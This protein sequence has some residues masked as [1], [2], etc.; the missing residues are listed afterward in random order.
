MN[1][2]WAYSVKTCGNAK[3]RCNLNGSPFEIKRMNLI[4]NKTY[5][6]C[7]DQVGQKTF[8]SLTSNLG[9]VAVGIDVVNGYAHAEAPAI[10]TFLVID[11]QYAEWYSQVNGKRS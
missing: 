8:W 9:Y 2:Q 6:A 3:A 5:A 10:D 11:D 7:V 1:F 4:I